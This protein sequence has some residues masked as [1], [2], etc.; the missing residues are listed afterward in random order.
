[1][2]YASLQTSIANWLN[3]D[4]LTTKIPEFI[5]MAEAEFN[6]VIRA[7][8][9]L[10]NA[11]TS[12]S[13]VSV[14]LPTDFLELRHVALTT[15]NKPLRHATLAELDDIRRNTGLPGEPTHVAVYNTK[16]ELAPVPDGTYTLE[17][18]Y[19]QTIPALSTSN[20]SNWLTAEY[21]DIYLYGALTKG[22]PYVGEDPTPWREEYQ[23]AVQQ[24]NA[25][26]ERAERKGRR[27]SL[28]FQAI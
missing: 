17:I 20:T 15:E 14:Q 9:M 6:R 8:Q 5:T 23:N 21:P 16:L 11:Q 1:M 18:V 10:R 26:S 25:V 24:L 27:K 28:A 3:R 7:R 13:V 2:D 4:D 12:T 22:A 19:Y